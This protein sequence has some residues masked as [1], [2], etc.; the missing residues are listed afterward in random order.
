MDNI[1]D[2]EGSVLAVH[3]AKYIWWLAWTLQRGRSLPEDP[4]FVKL[5]IFHLVG[6]MTSEVV[7]MSTGIPKL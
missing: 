3:F 5:A 2:P 7:I 1:A 4:N 6:T